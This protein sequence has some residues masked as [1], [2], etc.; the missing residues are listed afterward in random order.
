MIY[1]SIIY[2]APE[3]EC[4]ESFQVECI[5]TSPQDGGLESTVEE[6]WLI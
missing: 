6:E 3:C 5:C 4:E 2:T 1:T